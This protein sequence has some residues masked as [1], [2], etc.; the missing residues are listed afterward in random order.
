MLSPYRVLDLSDDQGI[1]CSF[2]LGELGAELKRVTVTELRDR[3]F[4]A[5]LLI[6]IGAEER[7]I[8]S[9]PSDAIALAVRSDVP[10][11]AAEAVLDE[12]G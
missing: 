9:R 1:F 7:T 2:V 12:A 6:E 10:I 11:F 3:T 4:Y 8:S 5:E